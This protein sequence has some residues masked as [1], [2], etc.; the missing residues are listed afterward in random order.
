MRPLP[1]MTA[2]SGSGG[3]PRRCR[4]SANAAA[5]GGYPC[6][7][8]QIDLGEAAIVPDPITSTS[9][10]AR[11]NPSSNRSAAL[12]PATILFDEGSDG[13]ATTPS[14]V[15]TKFANTRGSSNPSDPPYTEASSA[16]SSNAGSPGA[17]NS[18]SRLE[19]PSPSGT[20]PAGA[21]PGTVPVP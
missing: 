4:S 11:S 20:C 12:P 15:E 21:C 8:V 9:Q 1:E 3:R 13:I 2:T 7:A 19:R 6:S 14:S 17:S 18:T 10:Q 16:G 5:A